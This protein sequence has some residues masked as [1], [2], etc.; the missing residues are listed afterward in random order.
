MLTRSIRELVAA[1]LAEDIRSGD[2]TSRLT[3]EPVWEAHMA[4]RARAA[5]VFAGA[6]VLRATYDLVSAGAIHLDV[7]RADGD[8]LRAKQVIAEVTGPAV[9]VLAGERVALN[10]VQRMSGI[11]TL[12]AK[13]VT[14]VKGTR[15]QITDTRKTTPGLRILEKYAVR[16]GGGVNHRFALDDCVMI[17]DNHVDLYGMHMGVGRTDAV[18]ACVKAARKGAGHTVRILTEVE[19]AAEADAACDAGT[20]VVVLD[21]FELEDMRTCV[22][23]LRRRW[24][25]VIIEATG[26]IT[27]RR[28]GAVAATGVHV[29][30]VG[31]L[32]H[33]PPALD[34]GLDML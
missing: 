5:G 9:H 19:S 16:C 20:D 11:A 29:I 33:S 26:G 13:Y 1:A 18:S 6:E 23:R 7:L 4:I 3:V 14:A 17:K 34:L 15:A 10:F 31:E 25:S 12:T 2:L 21:N 22:R 8:R 32:T 27:L 30:S 24:P 28:V